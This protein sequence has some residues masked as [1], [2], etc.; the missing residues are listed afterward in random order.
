MSAFLA[1]AGSHATIPCQSLPLPTM[2]GPVRSAHTGQ[3]NWTL[4]V[5]CAWAR[6]R[7]PGV[8]AP[9]DGNPARIIDFKQKRHFGPFQSSCN[10]LVVCLH[11]PLAVACSLLS[12]CVMDLSLQADNAGSPLCLS[13]S[14]ESAKHLEPSRCAH[15]QICLTSSPFFHP[16]FPDSPFPP[17]G[18]GSTN[19]TKSRLD[20][21]RLLHL[22]VLPFVLSTPS[23]APLLLQG[24]L[25]VKTWRFLWCGL[26]G[27][28]G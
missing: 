18:Q 14:A 12:V 4:G 21:M 25:T 10:R 24:H 22:P 5:K 11:W 3:T 19:C 8:S 7:L 23:S 13:P 9:E 17:H 2:P 6:Y 1:C 15:T 28:N 27:Y 26:P 16:N 20:T